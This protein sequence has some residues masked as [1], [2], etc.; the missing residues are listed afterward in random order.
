MALVL[1]W[2]WSMKM[3]NETAD[4]RT[5]GS[6]R[7]AQHFD[8]RLQ[9]PTKSPVD[10]EWP[11]G[12]RLYLL[13]RG[14]RVAIRLHLRS[15]KLIIWII[16]RLIC[17]SSVFAAVNLLWVKDLSRK[18]FDTKQPALTRNRFTGQ[19]KWLE[20][21]SLHRRTEHMP[22]HL[23]SPDRSSPLDKRRHGTISKLDDSERRLLRSEAQHRQVLPR[24]RRNAGPFS[25]IGRWSVDHRI[26][27]LPVCGWSEFRPIPMFRWFLTEFQVNGVGAGRA[28]F[29]PVAARWNS[30]TIQRIVGFRPN[31]PSK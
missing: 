5:T 7:P 31:S 14:D 6:S 10:D 4:R 24:C 18:C 26:Q 30:I 20:R 27:H 29:L 22:G 23:T 8:L 12:G 11:S 1:C 25:L 16:G 2:L 15:D 28:S 19:R 17:G 9:H 13:I 21:W 3:T